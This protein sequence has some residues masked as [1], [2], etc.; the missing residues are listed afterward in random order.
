MAGDRG[1]KSGE[2]LFEFRQL[3]PQMRV[4]AIHVA[5]GTEVVV[6]APFPLKATGTDANVQVRGVSPRA[7]EVRPSIH[8]AQGRFLHPGL[9]ELFV[10]KNSLKT[11]VGLDL[12]STI[13]FNGGI[14]TVVG[15]FDSDGSAFDSEVWCDAVIL[16]QI[17]NRPVNIYQ[18]VTARLNSTALTILGQQQERSSLPLHFPL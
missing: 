4:A 13:K 11:Y 8:I 18:S 6:I 7:L 10:W 12:G 1:D 2:V 9:N 16:D 3:G 15:V 14:W 17:Y 5:T